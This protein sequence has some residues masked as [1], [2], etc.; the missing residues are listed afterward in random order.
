MNSKFLTLIGG[1]TGFLFSMSTLASCGDYPYQKIG[2]TFIPLENDAVKVISTYRVGVN[3]DDS[4]E[5]VDV[6]LREEQKQ[7]Y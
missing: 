2:A 3:F 7:K 5:V 6:L 4:D 1:I